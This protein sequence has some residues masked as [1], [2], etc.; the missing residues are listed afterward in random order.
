MRLTVFLA[1][2]VATAVVVAAVALWSGSS[3]WTAF[4][5]A[6]AS[7]LMARGEAARMADRNRPP[8]PGDK[9]K[10]PSAPLRTD[11]PS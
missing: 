8:Q 4:G 3:G 2:M 9:T 10:T 11:R 7:M 1:G 6:V 5:L